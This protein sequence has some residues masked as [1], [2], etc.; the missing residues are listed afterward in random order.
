MPLEDRQSFGADTHSSRPPASPQG[1]DAK[2]RKTG[3]SEARQKKAVRW[4]AK[5]QAY[6]RKAFIV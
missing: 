6:E 4:I 1:I 5:G 2:A 3:K